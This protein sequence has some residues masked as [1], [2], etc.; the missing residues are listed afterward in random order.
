MCVRVYPFVPA[1]RPWC[2]PAGAWPPSA[3][4]AKGHYVYDCSNGKVLSRFTALLYLND[5]FEG[6]WTTYF[7]PSP[8]VGVMN[9]FPVKPRAGSLV[10]FPHGDVTALLHEVRVALP[11]PSR[12][13]GCRELLMQ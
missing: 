8:D 1:I 6:G 3:L 12:G 10:I 7:T 11:A 4:D 13:C 2:G 9:A 5:D